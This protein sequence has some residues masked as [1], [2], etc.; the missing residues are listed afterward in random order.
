MDDSHL[1]QDGLV[2]LE[3]NGDVGKAQAEGYADV[4]RD[5]F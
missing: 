1:Y 2:L 5:E 3:M 4:L